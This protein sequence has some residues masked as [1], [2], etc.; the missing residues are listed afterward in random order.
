M[1]PAGRGYPTLV[2][3]LQPCASKTLSV[4]L[5]TTNTWPAE[6]PLSMMESMVPLVSLK[7]DQ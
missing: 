6:L 5:M 2:Q 1:A 4:G 3:S 7:R